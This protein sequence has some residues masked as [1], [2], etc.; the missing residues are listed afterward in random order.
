MRSF[1]RLQSVDPGF[2]AGAGA[3]V[4]A[5]AARRALR[6]GAAAGRV[7]RSAAAAPARA[8]GRAVG[9]RG[10][11]SLPLSGIELQHLA[12]R[13]RAVRQCR[14]RSSRRWRCASRRRTTSRRSASRSSAGA[15]SPTTTAPARRGWCS[16]P[17]ARRGSIFPNEDPIGKTIK[18]G[19]GRGP[20]K[21]RAGGR[22]RRHRRRRQ[23]R[24][25]RRADPPQIYLPYRQWPV[26]RM[27]VV[28]KTADAAGV[29]RRSRRGARSTRSIR[30]CRVVERR[31]RSSR[32][33]PS[34]SRSRG[35]T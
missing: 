21:P 35:S 14:R 25:A 22:S 23:G 8:A 26:Q 1:V 30:T 28:M 20:G 34:R 19:W 7:L 2:N 17:R 24:R 3:D 32:S 33:S 12:S 5:V 18:L 31:A 29:A 4:R 16:S 27:S 9:R 13:S 15:C 6:G 10:A 11:W